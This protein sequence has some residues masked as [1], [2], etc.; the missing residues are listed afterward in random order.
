MRSEIETLQGQV[1]GLHNEYNRLVIEKKKWVNYEQTM[2][3]LPAR[4]KDLE[5]ESLKQ[6]PFV[7]EKRPGY[8]PSSKEEFDRAGDD[9][10][11]ASY[12]F[13]VD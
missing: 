3:T 13:L 11:N 9:L 2:S 6:E 10:A 5:Y 4:V 7:L 1:N 8:H 12:P